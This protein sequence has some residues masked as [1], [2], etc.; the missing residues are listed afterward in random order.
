MKMKKI[1]QNFFI[2]RTLPTKNYASLAESLRASYP[3]G[4]IQLPDKPIKILDDFNSTRKSVNVEGRKSANLD[5]NIN[6][7]E[8]TN[9]ASYTEGANNTI[10][11]DDDSNPDISR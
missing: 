4:D 3:D 7:Y 8:V 2:F 11:I 10:T 1:N 5:G 9:H 6:S